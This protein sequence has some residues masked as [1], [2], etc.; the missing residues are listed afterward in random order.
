MKSTKLFPAVPYQDVERVLADS[1]LLDLAIHF[2]TDF[3]LLRESVQCKTRKADRGLDFKAYVKAVNRDL[4]KEAKAFRKIMPRRVMRFEKLRIHADYVIDM[5]SDDFSSE[6]FLDHYS[7]VDAHVRSKLSA[8]DGKFDVDGLLRMAIIGPAMKWGKY[9]RLSEKDRAQVVK[10]LEGMLQAVN[11][12]IS[13]ARLDADGVEYQNNLIFCYLCVSQLLRIA[14]H[15]SVLS[16]HLQVFRRAAP[17]AWEAAPLR[18]RMQ[19]ASLSLHMA[20]VFYPLDRPFEPQMGLSRNVLANL[21]AVLEDAAGTSAE[22]PF[23]THQWVF[24]WVK[25]KL[26]AE[27]FSTRLE[28][29]QPGSLAVLS[30]GEQAIAVEL[31]RRFASYRHPVTIHHLE[32]FLL[33]F[34]TTARIRAALRLLT[35]TKFFPLWE[36]GAVMERLLSKA[37]TSS[38]S[39]PLVV[40]PLGDQSGST[41][42]LRYLAGHSA[43]A[44]RLI[45]ADSLEE[46]LS[47]TK[48]NDRL[49]FVDDCLLSG[50]QTLN[51]LG[52]LMGTRERKPHHT[53]HTEPLSRQKRQAFL[54]RSL[55]FCYCVATDLGHKRFNDLVAET[56]IDPRS[57]TLEVGVVEHSS[58]KAFEAMGP[59]AWASADE[60]D[61]LKTFASAVGFDILE[62]RADMKG[63]DDT[64]RLESA[65]GFS[66]FQRLLVFPYNVPKTTVT[67]LW[68]R[69]SGKRPWQPLFLGF[70]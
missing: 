52:D 15:P 50:T 62:K 25:D 31:A 58:S 6:V 13:L 17:S 56:G 64:R 19:Y 47:L 45:F 27:M 65:L 24:R 9:E 46:A 54:K 34:G 1:A 20:T 51:I 44:G 61:E 69:S 23:T 14:V 35:H 12:T 41:A 26:D 4:S 39:S 37:S 59:V 42:I 66:D 60:R 7:R 33:Q 48:P 21:R 5:R 18:V 40:A 53:A 2:D 22:A 16:H 57:A 28:M 43:L 55:S 68:E 38:D 63:W 29:T 30:T 3:E 70:D 36:L 32:S 8:S 49:F 67:L 10:T 11:A